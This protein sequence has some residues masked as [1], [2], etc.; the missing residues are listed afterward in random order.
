VNSDKTLLPPLGESRRAGAKKEEKKRGGGRK[1]SRTCR[2]FGECPF[3]LTRMDVDNQKK[4]KRKKE[5]NNGVTWRCNLSPQ[6][7]L[8]EKENYISKS[9]CQRKEKRGKKERG[10]GIILVFP[11]P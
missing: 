1:S 2:S 3:P 4:R 6:P 8:M 11:F 9:Q 5:K 10:G 7:P